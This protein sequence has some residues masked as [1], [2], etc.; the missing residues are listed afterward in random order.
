MKSIDRLVAE[1]DVIERGLAVLEKV[2]AQIDSGESFPDDF[3]KWAPQFFR[4]FADQCHHAKEEDLLFPLLKERGIPEK[5]GPIGVMLQEH[6]L[7]R[8]CV[9][10][11]REAS[12]AAE[13]DGPDFAAAANEFTPLLRQHIYKENNILFRMAENVL[14]EADDADLNE[15]FSQVEQERGLDGLHEQYEAEVARWEEAVE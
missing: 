6:V 4:Q 8:D 1:H 11:M 5:G 10:R 14:S 2:V 7:G 12:E 9:R 13:F 15:Q 3:P